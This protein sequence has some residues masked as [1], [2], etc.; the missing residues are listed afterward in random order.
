MSDDQHDNRSTDG[1][2]RAALV[3]LDPIA[4]AT[5]HPIDPI[6]SDRARTLLEAIMS[7]PLIDDVTPARSGATPARR[8][9]RRWFALGGAGACR[10]ELHRD[11]LKDLSVRSAAVSG[12]KECRHKDF[13][14]STQHLKSS[15][16]NLEHVRGIV[17]IFL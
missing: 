16:L 2:L 10:P 17:D 9:R 13:K 4:D 14:Q 5:A 7:T 1:P 11:K 3:A 6:T 12:G 15:R 8:G